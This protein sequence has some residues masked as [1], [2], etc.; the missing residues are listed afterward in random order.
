MAQSNRHVTL[1]RGREHQGHPYNPAWLLII[2]M[3]RRQM[4]SVMPKQQV[5][6]TVAVVEHM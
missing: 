2:G 4:R 5:P 3:M 6:L 1:A